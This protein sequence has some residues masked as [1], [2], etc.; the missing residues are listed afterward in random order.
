[1]PPL[2][3]WFDGRADVAAFLHASVFATPWRARE[4][5][6]VNGHPAVLGEQLWEGEWRPGALM[7]LHLHEGRIGWLATFIGP[8][9]AAWAADLPLDR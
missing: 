7:I 3:A 1:M 6:V 4:V 5:G 9:C 2:Q 8:M